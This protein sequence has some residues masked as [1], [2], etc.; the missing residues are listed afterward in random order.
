MSLSPR[1]APVVAALLVAVVAAPALAS[2]AASDPTQAASCEPERIDPIG[3][4]CR[5]PDGDYRVFLE[6]GT[7][8][9]THGPDPIPDDG[10]P[11]LGDDQRQPV[12]AWRSRLHVLYGHPSSKPDRSD[13]VADDLRSVVRHMNAVLNADA[14]ASGGV[15]A[16]YKVACDGEGRIAVDA[17]SGPDTTDFSVIVDAARDEGYNRGETDYVI[18]WDDRHGTYCGVGNYE[19]DDRLSE[20]NANMQGPDYGVNYQPCWEGRTPM[21]ENG[22]NQ[23]AVQQFAPKSDGAGHCLDGYD[24]MCYTSDVAGLVLCT[25]RT[26]YDCDDDTYFD[27]DPEEGEWLADHWNIGSRLNR[28]IAFGDRP[29]PSPVPP[30]ADLSLRL[31]RRNVSGDPG[32]TVRTGLVVANDGDGEGSYRLNVSDL[33]DGWNATLDEAEG[34]LEGGAERNHT[35]EVEIPADADPGSSTLEVALSSEGQVVDSGA[36]TVRVTGTAWDLSVSA[37]PRTAPVAPGEDAAF[38]LEVAHDGPRNLTVAIDVS[39]LPDRVDWSADPAEGRIAPGQVLRSELTVSVGE[40]LDDRLPFQ[41]E[42]T[43]SDGVRAEAS[44]ELTPVLAQQAPAGTTVPFPGPVLAVGAV[45]VAAWL[46]RH[47]RC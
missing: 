12:C 18:F 27:A 21:H 9:R 4:A 35:A 3:R 30:S 47:R 5:L 33:P 40:P 11:G 10:D 34:T 37:T 19:R 7:T 26:R 39:G 23:G 22:H 38:R 20:D 16:D 17:F 8:L 46:A 1:W 42:V 25:E 24:V 6:D 44:L 41:V 13:E 43:G 15:T 29:L 32:G 2:L 28:Y 45:A 31:D 14:Q 36:L